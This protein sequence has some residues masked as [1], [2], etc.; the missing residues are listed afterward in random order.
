M[1]QPAL[2]TWTLSMTVITNP[3]SPGAPSQ[4]IAQSQPRDPIGGIPFTSHAQNP[5]IGGIATTFGTQ[6]VRVSNDLV[7]AVGGAMNRQPR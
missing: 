4:V 5:A 3:A 1:M 6:V 2:Q 7:A